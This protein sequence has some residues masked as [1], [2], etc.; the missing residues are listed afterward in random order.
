MTFKAAFIFIAPEVDLKTTQHEFLTPGISLMAAGVSTYDEAVKLA[1]ELVKNGVG[2]IEL[3]AG[4]GHEGVAKVTK[5][6]HAINSDVKVGVVRFDS[7]PGFDYK[8]GDELF[9]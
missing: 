4:F 9:Q 7:H 1:V 2:A 8:S 5:A 6:V 3:C